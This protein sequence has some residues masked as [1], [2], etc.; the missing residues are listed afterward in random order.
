MGL[1]SA[2]L[3]R[4]LRSAQPAASAVAAGVLYYVT[5]EGITEQSNGVAWL[6]HAD[7]GVASGIVVPPWF[8]EVGDREAADAWMPGPPGPPGPAGAPGGG[9]GGGLVLLEQHTASASAVLDFT[10]GITATYDS[11][12]LDIV[13]LLAASASASLSLQVSTDGGATF[14]TTNYW[15]ALNYL[16]SAAGA[17]NLTSAAAGLIN[18]GGYVHTAGEGAMG[19]VRFR[20]PASVLPKEFTIN[21]AALHNDTNRY[22]FRGAGWWVNTVAINAIRIKFDTGNIT[23]GTVRL[24]GIAK[25]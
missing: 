15:Y 18:L 24:Y 4:G 3:Q 12:M 1:P 11:Y 19:E 23:S 2:I 13:G 25:T 5:D 14:E 20:N 9:G 16:S 6:T 8:G 17:G 22:V 7:R 21:L 10:T